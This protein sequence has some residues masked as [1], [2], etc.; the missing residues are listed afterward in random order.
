LYAEGKLGILPTDLSTTFLF[1]DDWEERYGVQM[2]Y[3]GV[4]SE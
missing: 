1:V 3:I 4:D 2:D